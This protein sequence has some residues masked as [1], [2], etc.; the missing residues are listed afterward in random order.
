[1]LFLP[2]VPEG[3]IAAAA[4]DFFYFKGY[5]PEHR[6][7]RLVPDGY[8]SLVIELDD[9]L[10]HVYD[11]ETLAPKQ[12]CK[13]AWFSGLHQHFISIGAEPDSELLAIRFRPGLAY[14]L[15]QSPLTEVS[16]K[17]VPA[18]DLFGDDIVVLRQQIIAQSEPAAKLRLVN[19]WL[20]KRYSKAHQV[21]PIIQAA[22]EAIV[23][24]PTAS[25]LKEVLAQEGYSAKHFIHLFKRYVGLPPKTFQRIMRFQQVIPLIHGK[26]KVNWAQ[27]G[28][29]CGYYDQA[30]FI[31]D[32]Q[33][34]SGYNPSDFLDE[35]HE[36]LN[37]FPVDS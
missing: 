27:V 35:Q 14:P 32:F 3:P 6:I 34:F 19:D 13:V 4:S 5:Q 10:R 36:R 17:V 1:M 2:H 15:L 31:K 30:H 7:E 20:N 21:D 28:T 37:F 23:A 12:D 22:I 33:L 24:A 29:E 16:D 25:T 9:Q 8:T 26:E 11:N 18:T